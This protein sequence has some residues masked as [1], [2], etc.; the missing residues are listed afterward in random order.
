MAWSADPK[1]GLSDRERH[2]ADAFKAV[3]RNLS[4]RAAVPLPA[5]R[6]VLPAGAGRGD[7]G[8][9]A[10]HP[11]DEVR[12][13]RQSCHRWSDGNAGRN[14]GRG[15]RQ[16]GLRLSE[17]AGKDA[18][19]RHRRRA[20]RAPGSGG[21]LRALEQTTGRGGGVLQRQPKKTPAPL[22]AEGVQIHQ[23]YG[24]S[25]GGAAPAGRVHLRGRIHEGQG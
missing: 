3:Q 18:S 25:G 13:L 5:K 7:G 10:T 24:H 15:Q 17:K 20:G 1:Q 22:S 8:H 2:R 19:G 11:G 4:G 23:E 14:A 12:T 9:G 16:K 21:V 6:S